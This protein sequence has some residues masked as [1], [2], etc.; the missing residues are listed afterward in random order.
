MP[1]PPPIGN[2]QP[3]IRHPAQP[4]PKLPHLNL[5]LQPPPGK[6]PPP[7]PRV[8]PPDVRRHAP[9]R[10]DRHGPLLQAQAPDRRRAHHRPRRHHPGPDPRAPPKAPEGDRHG[11]HPHHPRPRRRRR[12]RRHR[13]GHV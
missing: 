2:R 12:E 7:P 11:H 1:P 4:T 9:A 10:H 13:R 8:P 6:T 5:A 3:A